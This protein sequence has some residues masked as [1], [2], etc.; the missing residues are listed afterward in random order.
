MLG[1][2]NCIPKK[3]ARLNINMIIGAADLRT[4]LVKLLHAK[5]LECDDHSIRVSVLARDELPTFYLV[6]PAPSCGAILAQEV[7]RLT[8]RLLLSHS[9]AWLLFDH[10]AELIVRSLEGP[11]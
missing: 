6:V 8:G 11:R 9:A 4:A 5:G 3:T 1:R 7:S 10:D 2:R